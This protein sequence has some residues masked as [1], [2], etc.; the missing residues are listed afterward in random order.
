MTSSVFYLPFI[1]VIF[2]MANIPWLSDRFMVFLRIAEKNVWLRWLEWL[3]LYVIAGVLAVGMEYKLTGV[4][5][6]QE[7]EFY[8]TTLC[9]FVVFALPGFIYHYDLKKYLQKR[10][11]D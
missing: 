9:L 4:H 10:S 2:A 3:L 8:V 5:Y 11:T 1:A 6:P 7:W